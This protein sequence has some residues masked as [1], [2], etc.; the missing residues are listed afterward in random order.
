MLDLEG[1]LAP[2][3]ATAPSGAD[4]RYSPDY[5]DL[6]RAIEGKPERQAG[7]AIV[8][9]EPPDWKAVREKCLGLLKVSKD[10]RVA[11]ILVRALVEG[12]GFAGFADGLALVLGL[13]TTHWPTLH[14]QL[15]AEDD[16]DPTARIS[17]MGELTHRNMIQVLRS[18]PL[19]TG[20]PFPPV[21]LRTLEIA[22]AAKTP[23]PKPAAPAPGAPAAP[24][25]ANA[26]TLAAIEAV[27]QHVSI[28]VLGQTTTILARCVTQARALA[29][30]WAEKL[31]SA[32]PDFTELRR[33]LAQADQAVRSRMDQRK[34]PENGAAA[35]GIPG[36][37][38][39]TVALAPVVRGEIQSRD[40][41]L[42][43]L[44]AICAYYARS[45]PSSPV[46]LLLQR[47]KRLVTM[48]FVDILKEMLPESLPNMQKIAGKTD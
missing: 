21:T 45:E 31:P 37:E 46:P 29:D 27:F 36:A 22:A 12:E 44:D 38:G 23:P 30:E 3:G 33:L 25:P 43:S 4:I 1:L 7:G 9:A 40:D 15:D 34:A 39:G 26:P 10:L 17:A 8:A 16:N 13:V 2:L 48:S 24:A 32:G 28:E 14:P 41:V 11:V 18:A 42:R 20:G 5:V 35:P 19:A 47:G 6:E